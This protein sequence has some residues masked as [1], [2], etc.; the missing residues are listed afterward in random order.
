MGSAATAGTRSARQSL[1]ETG[2]PRPGT[3][4]VREAVPGPAT[5]PGEPPSHPAHLARARSGAPLPSA[6]SHP[7]HHHNSVRRSRPA[8]ERA[9]RCA[10]KASQV[11]RR[12]TAVPACSAVAARRPRGDKLPAGPGRTDVRGRDGS[13]RPW[14]LLDR[15]GVAPFLCPVGAERSAFLGEP[16]TKPK[17]KET[18]MK[19]LISQIV[20]G[21]LELAGCLLRVSFA[22]ARRVG[23]IS[24]ADRL[25][26]ILSGD[27]RPHRGVLVSGQVHGSWLTNEQR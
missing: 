24:P 3:V 5:G 12:C 16:A 25:D 9:G 6:V 27:R 2:G 21:L 17:K 13:S 19:A 14:A 1:R 22:W 20:T 23:R 26:R 18:S 7:A 4:F 10:R 15:P 11:L 8:A